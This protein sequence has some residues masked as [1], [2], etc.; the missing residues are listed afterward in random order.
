MSIGHEDSRRAEIA[1]R[2]L[3]QRS[4]ASRYVH[5]PFWFLIAL[6][7]HLNRTV[8][9]VFWWV[10]SLQLAALLG[11]LYNHRRMRAALAAGKPVTHRLWL[12]SLFVPCVIWS[13]LA[14]FSVQPGA[15][16]AAMAPLLFMVVGAATAGT[17][18]LSIDATVRFWYPMTALL[19]TV[20][21][22]FLDSSGDHV[23][24][25]VMAV[26]LIG[27]VFL[28]TKVVHDDYWAAVLARDLLEHRAADLETLSTTDSLTGLAN[29]RHFEARFQQAWAQAVRDR[30]PLSLML[31]DLDH[32]KRINDTHGHAAGD[33]CLKAAA[34]SLI[35]A[36]PRRSDVVARWGG[37]EFVVLLAGTN[38]A[39]AAPL[40]ERVVRGMEG[41]LVP[42]ERAA[43]RFSC[44]VGLASCVPTAEDAATDLILDADLALYAAK[45]QGRNR[46][47]AGRAA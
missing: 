11:R 2:D 10:T 15:L 5:L 8:P 35:A 30:T 31:I 34:K 1:L 3:L 25:G 47:V 4:H 24:L 44:S 36:F 38:A 40:A 26:A 28:A 39:D 17:I 12:V 13:A 9:Q 32:F 45:E 37:E 19:P 20:A 27:Y 7:T 23:L 14:G 46:M 42:Y 29:R 21:A 16:H 6:P 41:T 43:I 18:V 22:M 33:A